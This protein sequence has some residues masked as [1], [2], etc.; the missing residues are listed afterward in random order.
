[1]TPTPTPHPRSDR[2]DSGPSVHT[3]L[4]REVERLNSERARTDGDRNAI[5][6]TK[7]A[8]LTLV[9][10]ALRAGAVLREH[11]A[12]A[13]A[14]LQVLS[15]RMTFRAGDR[16]LDLASGDLVAME[17]GLAHAA[18]AQEDTAFLLTIVEGGAR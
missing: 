8:G 6:L 1:M 10:T 14:T 2:P 3:R 13:A 7:G 17:A 11:R 18:E 16:S 9:L 12:P 15:G 5:T 4:A